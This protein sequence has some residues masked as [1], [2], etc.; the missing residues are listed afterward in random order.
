LLDL[1]EH[2]SWRESRCLQWI[3]SSKE[4]G[5]R[6]RFDIPMKGSALVA[7]LEV[8]TL[9]AG[10]RYAE[11]NT[12]LPLHNTYNYFNKN[13]SDTKQL[14]FNKNTHK[15]IILGIYIFG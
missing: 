8:K 13:A 15:I 2:W 12:K 11:R 10:K 5:H 4:T 1:L 6:S 7:L 14:F 9:N 3:D